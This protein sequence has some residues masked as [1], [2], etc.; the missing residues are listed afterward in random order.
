[1]RSCYLGRSFAR[2]RGTRGL[3][4]PQTEGLDFVLRSVRWR[5]AQVVVAGGDL[6]QVG[7]QA[8]RCRAIASHEAG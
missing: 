2:G 6:E 3:R 7:G 4:S 8:A 1:M 5:R